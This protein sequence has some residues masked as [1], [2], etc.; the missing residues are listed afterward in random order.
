MYIKVRNISELLQNVYRMS[1]ILE[2]MAVL[3]TLNVC[4]YLLQI[5]NICLFKN[6]A[7]P[8]CQLCVRRET[9]QGKFLMH[10]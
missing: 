2:M 9:F 4:H 8:K 3:P 7:L 1:K 6:I 10:E 5:L